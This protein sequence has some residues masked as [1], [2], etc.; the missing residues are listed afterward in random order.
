MINYDYSS[1]VNRSNNLK[2]LKAG[3]SNYLEVASIADDYE[4]LVQELL[5]IVERQQIDISQLERIN[6]GKRRR[7]YD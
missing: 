3:T 5:V 7:Y 2:K 4:S 1:L 6:A